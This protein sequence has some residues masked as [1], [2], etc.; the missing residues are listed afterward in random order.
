M[1]KTQLCPHKT[2]LSCKSNF[3]S[4]SLIQ[5]LLKTNKKKHT[6]ALEKHL[7]ESSTS[8]NLRLVERGIRG[9]MYLIHIYIYI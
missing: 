4:F 3:S 6:S 5:P 9:T 8:K 7:T 1:L 2:S